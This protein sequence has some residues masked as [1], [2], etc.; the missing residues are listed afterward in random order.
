MN[1]GKNVTCACQKSLLQISVFL[2]L[3]MQHG[4]PLRARTGD[5]SLAR[6]TGFVA[7][8]QM[9]S[10]NYSLGLAFLTQKANIS[11]ETRRLDVIRPH[12]FRCWLLLRHRS[13]LIRFQRYVYQFLTN[14]V[15][16]CVTELNPAPYWPFLFT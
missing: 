6:G 4:R 5:V 11:L 12:T 7:H 15:R 1:R 14:F 10:C 2:C 13:A 3:K 9:N 8:N 16:F